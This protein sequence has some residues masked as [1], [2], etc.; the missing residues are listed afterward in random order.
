MKYDCFENDC[1]NLYTIKTDKFKSCHMEIVF[2][3]KCTKENITYLALLFDIL[4]ENCKEYPTK[5]MLARKQQ[6]LYNLNVYSVNSRV[7][8]TILSNIVA[9]FLDPKYMDSTSLEEIIKLIF[10]LIFNPNIEIDEFENSTF[11]RVKKRLKSEIEALKEDPK[12]SSIL[13][14]LSNIDSESPRSFNSSGDTKILDSITPKKLYKFYQKVLDNSLVDIYIVGNVDMKE[15]NK[16]CKKYSKFS[17]IK[18]E[19]LNLFLDDITIKKSFNVKDTNSFT[20]TN[21]VQVYT[22][23]NLDNWETNYVV[24]IFNLVWGSGSLESKLFKTVRG[25]NS[26][27]YGI[28]TFYQKYDKVIILHT[29]IDGENYNQTLKLIK[30]C[31]GDMEKGNISEEELSNVKSIL[32]NSLNLIY[33]SPNRLADNYLF[34]NIAA[35]PEVEKRIEEFQKVTIEDLVK[36]SKKMHLL[37]N[38]RIGE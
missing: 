11:E 5:K 30:K 33:D 4:M 23:K 32:I 24:P 35:L 10:T 16:L 2:R 28:N 3:N 19:K 14:A 36:L 20:Q 26:L 9:D 15:I 25:E 31:L 34:T 6:D 27:C 1:Y 22:F 38:Y 18:T 13:S 29:A 17:S 7:G 8:D 37:I 21:V 12:Q